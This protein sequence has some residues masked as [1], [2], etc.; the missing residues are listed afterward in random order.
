MLLLDD[1]LTTPISAIVAQWGAFG[2]VLVLVGAFAY[3]QNRELNKARK[4]HA[5]QIAKMQS[6]HNAATQK[7]QREHHEALIAAQRE[8]ISDAQQ[9]TQTLLRLQGQFNET[10]QAVNEQ[11]SHN[12]HGLDGVRTLLHAIDRRVESLDRRV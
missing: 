10:T 4:E 2:A 3:I 9:V 5:D 6:E 11:L 12:A 8:R 7:M 1:A